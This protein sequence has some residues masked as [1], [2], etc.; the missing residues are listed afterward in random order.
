ML[1][2]WFVKY[3]DG[4]KQLLLP[5]HAPV[6]GPTDPPNGDVVLL[7]NSRSNTFPNDKINRY[8]YGFPSLQSRPQADRSCFQIQNDQSIA[9]ST[10]ISSAFCSSWTSRRSR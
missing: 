3:D 5:L 10:I 2:E 7:W 9:Q 8:L 4:I 1:M 6:P